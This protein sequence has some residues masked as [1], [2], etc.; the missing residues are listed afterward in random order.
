M[1]K[2]PRLCS[3]PSAALIPAFWWAETLLCHN[4]SEVA[5][6]FLLS[7]VG[8]GEVGGGW[9]SL[10]WGG[11]GG[12]GATIDKDLVVLLATTLAL[13]LPVLVGLF[14]VPV[15]LFPVADL[16]FGEEGVGAAAV[17]GVVGGVEGVRDGDAKWRTKKKEKQNNKRN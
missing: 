7:G 13:V 15:G 17:D 9:R 2:P 4:C 1:L 6:D 5:P 10:V 11:L 16:G 14:P 12:V 8:G 3:P